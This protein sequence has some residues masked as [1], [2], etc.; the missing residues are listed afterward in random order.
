MKRYES[1]LKGMLRILEISYIIGLVL[2]I[3]CAIANY[4]SFSITILGEAIVL[5][6]LF[7]SFIAVIWTC[8]VGKGSRFTNYAINIITSLFGGLF[9]A[10]FG[11][12]FLIIF[13]AIKFFVYILVAIIFALF[14]I[15]SFPVSITY[16][17]I[18]YFIEKNKGEINDA[19]ADKLDKIVP[20]TAGVLTIVIVILIFSPQKPNSNDISSI[21]PAKE[22]ITQENVQENT[23]STENASD[24]ELIKTHIDLLD[25]VD[26]TFSGI[27]PSIDVV[28][29]LPDRDYFDYVDTGT[30]TESIEANNGDIYTVEFNYKEK[31]MKEA[32]YS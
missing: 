21:E 19:L 12:M 29:T 27:C 32:G 2:A 17:T 14:L 31:E 9:G 20:L 11:S 8:I 28:I 25:G 7:G 13:F 30:L 22:S 5:G 24:S 10:G 6:L 1:Q 15:I 4:K 23:S 26:V 18:M 3:I 16:M